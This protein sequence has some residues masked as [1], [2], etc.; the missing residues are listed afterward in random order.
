MEN[1]ERPTDDSRHKEDGNT[2]ENASNGG[3]GNQTQKRGSGG[4]RKKKSPDEL[5][6]TEIKIQEKLA[7]FLKSLPEIAEQEHGYKLTLVIVLGFLRIV[8]DE[9][10]FR[11]LLGIIVVY[12]SLT[13]TSIS[14]MTNVSLVTIREGKKGV[15]SGVLPNFHRQRNKGGGRKKVADTHAWVVKEIEKYVE[16]RSY[17]P[18][19]KEIAEYTAA[20]LDSIQSFLKRHFGFEISRG[21]I[22]NILISKGIILRTNKK[23]LYGNQGKETDLQRLVRHAQFEYIESLFVDINDPTRIYV[24]IDCKQKIN[25]G[26]TFALWKSYAKAGEEVKVSDHNFFTPLKVSALNDMDDLLERE[27]GKAIPYGIYDIC[28]NK[29]YVNI[30]ISSDTPEFVVESLRQFLPEILKDH[31][32]AKELYLF[33]DGGGSNSARS[34]VLK[35]YLTLLSHEIGMKIY[36]IHYPPYRSKF[37]KIERK[38]FAPISK[39]FERCHLSNLLTV[40]TLIENT[41]SKTGMKLKARVDTGIYKTGKKLTDKEIALIKSTPVGNTKD[42]PINLAF[43]IDGMALK[44]SDIPPTAKRLTVFDVKENIHQSLEEKAAAKAAKEATKAAKATAKAQKATQGSKK[45]PSKAVSH[46]IGG[47]LVVEMG[48]KN[49]RP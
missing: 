17:G 34:I 48:H 26:V 1:N 44:D 13:A 32:R 46:E 37:N 10:L 5:S 36:I 42:L 4:A 20:T 41:P 25:L 6:Q 22:R 38:M 21:T 3:D 2:L 39:Q 40:K 28:M 35:Y 43:E 19:T 24:S 9:N 14:K 49:N 16:L 45:T 47:T 8:L 12:T 23:L 29:G 15:L 18:C 30:G 7:D 33:C 31:P 27:E 11:Y